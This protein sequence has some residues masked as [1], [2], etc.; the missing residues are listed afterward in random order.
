[1]ENDNIPVEENNELNPNVQ[2]GVTEAPTN[3][4]ETITTPTPE[5]QLENSEPQS[6]PIP[7]PT[8]TMTGMAPILDKKDNSKKGIALAIPVIIA[9]II[10]GVLLVPKLLITGKT[11][12]KKEVT[13]FFTQAKKA[14]EESEKNLLEYDL[15]KDSLGV[16]GSL[17]IDSNYVGEGIDLS[18]LK[19]Y[20]LNYSG[21]I[22]KKQN[23]ASGSLKLEKNASALLSLDAY[24]QGKDGVLSLGDLYNKGI[25]NEL[26]K[27]IK[28]L[29]LSKNDNIKDVKL[30]LEK[31]EVIVKDTID[32]EDIKKEK[33]E[34]EFNGKKA[35]YTKVEYKIYMEKLAKKIS[36]A[37]LKDNE[38][39]KA[40]AN[41]SNTTEKDVKE[42]L[43]D[44]GNDEAEEDTVIT[45]N[46]YLKGMSTT[47]KAFE[48]LDENEVFEVV[49]DNGKY[50]YRFIEDD[51][52]YFK[53]EYLPEQQTLTLTSE[54]GFTITLKS[55]D[56]TTNMDFVYKN[57]NQEMNINATMKNTV[58]KSSQENNT[59]VSFK[60]QI[61][62]EKIEATLTNEMKIEKNQKAEKITPTLTVTADNITEEEYN[63]MMNKLYEKIGNILDDIMPG[64]ADNAITDF[65]KQM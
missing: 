17:T 62:D 16:T 40:L 33:V 4:Q 26:E 58:S 8:D 41:L 25:T 24:I 1:M 18:K 51:K 39:I 55:T 61:D 57:D 27:E 47:P 38:V 29:D 32:D 34:K 2:E 7:Q 63:S 19:N 44:V 20:H 14:L 12:V 36:E 6:D 28:D 31:T 56:N 50:L 13:S 37:Y 45:L 65:R 60:Y 48:L 35:N 22:D 59:V 21:V 64:I 5:P 53:G 30:L 10:L 23:E 54:E 3:N 9:L 49:E 15:E 46:L 11:V 42:T 52:E 43:Q